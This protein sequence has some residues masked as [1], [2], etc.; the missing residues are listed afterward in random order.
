M[1]FGVAAVG[2]L[3]YYLLGNKAEKT[4]NLSKSLKEIKAL[5]EPKREANGL[6]AFSYY[7]DIISIIMKNARSDFA[8]EKKQLLVQRRELLRNNKTEEYKE[9]VMEMVVKEEKVGTDLLG[10]ALDHI[11]LSESESMQTHEIYM[12]DPQIQKIIMQA[13]MGGGDANTK[14]PPSITRQK[15]K[16]IFFESEERKFESM[17]KMM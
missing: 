17:K 11:G 7:K 1:M 14:T 5:G 8:E 3:S 13:Q 6:L 15:A 12:K 4:D 9:L 16:E 2:I 10:D